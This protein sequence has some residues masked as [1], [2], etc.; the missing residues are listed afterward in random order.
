MFKIDILGL[1]DKLSHEN[2]EKDETIHE[3]QTLLK[4]RTNE[5]KEL[6]TDIQQLNKKFNRL[7]K[8]NEKQSIEI[9]HL[10]KDLEKANTEINRITMICEVKD[11]VIRDTHNDLQQSF[12]E[13]K[14]LNNQIGNLQ[15]NIEYLCEENIRLR[16]ELNEVKNN[17]NNKIY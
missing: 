17:A 7:Y 11:G 3:L 1:C 10:Y 12:N 16:H 13:I 2:E 4:F 9:N 14:L 15:R 8:D 6:Y 5:N